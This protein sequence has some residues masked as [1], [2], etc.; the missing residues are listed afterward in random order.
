MSGYLANKMVQYRLC[1]ILCVLACV[2]PL[3]M[4]IGL[5]NMIIWGIILLLIGAAMAYRIYSCAEGFSS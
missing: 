4:A 3:F 1:L 5:V 2:L